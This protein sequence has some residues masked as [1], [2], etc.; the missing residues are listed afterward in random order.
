MSGVTQDKIEQAARRLFLAKSIVVLTGAGVS[1]ESGIPT[2]RD[3][4]DGLWAKFNPQEL[5][6]RQAFVKNPKLVWDWY[7]FRREAFKPKTPNPGHYAIVA[8]DTLVPDTVV[9][10]QNID[11]LHQ[12]AGSRDVIELH[13]NISRHKCL[14]DCQGTP[15]LIDLS[16]LTWDKEAGPPACPYCG[17][18]I[19]PDVVWFNEV[20]PIDALTRATNLADSAEV[21]LVAGTSGVVEPAASLP[22]RARYYNDAFVIDV[23]P[24][25]N[26]ITDYA[27]LFLE[28]PSGVILPQVIDAMRAFK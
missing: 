21:V 14:N 17:A 1:K 2:F 5:A 8:L 24:E 27:D 10:T 12:M 4:Q 6:T 28:G 11:G 7:E 20:L 15:T 25:R 13:G 26:P 22:Y 19:R 3:S 18:F 16:T 9:V 23:N